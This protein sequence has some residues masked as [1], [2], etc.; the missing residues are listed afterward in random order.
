[1]K[2]LY[3]KLGIQHVLTTA[4]HPQS[5]SQ[6]K[7]ANQEVKKHLHQ[8]TNTLQNDWVNHLPTTKFVFNSLFHS[9]LNMSFVKVMY[10]YH[11]NFTVPIGTPSKWPVLKQP[12]EMLGDVP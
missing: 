3:E 12:L 4:Y 10:R 6:T 9:T 2:A 7:C 1:M 8:F 5:N 11:P